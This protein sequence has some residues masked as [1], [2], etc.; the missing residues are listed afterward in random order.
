MKEFVKFLLYRVWKIWKILDVSFT[1]RQKQ[2]AEIKANIDV[3]EIGD[4]EQLGLLRNKLRNSR[5]KYSNNSF[6]KIED[7]TYGEPRI[8]FWNDK[9]NLTIGKF[10]S[11][12]QNVTIMLGGNHHID[13]VSTYPF[14]VLLKNFSYIEALVSQQSCKILL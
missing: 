11:I 12:A 5:T 6:I 4:I 3:C 14:P 10:C 8:V 13:W 1:I 7:F 2:K 9:T